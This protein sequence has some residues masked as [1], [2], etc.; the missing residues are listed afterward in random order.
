M[1]AKT[2]KT[3]GAA[4][5]FAVL[6]LSG[7]GAPPQVAQVMNNPHAQL[8]VGTTH[9]KD[10]QRLLGAPTEH[11]A[12]DGHGE[13]WV[14]SDI[15]KVPLAVSLIPLI[16]DAADLAELEHKNRE[17]IVQFDQTGVLRRLKVRNIE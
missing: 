7:C 16:G 6:L 8:V 11:H 12:G 2:T 14:Y 3:T 9:Q 17:L 1:H 5:L 4:L 15:V 10:V 13:V